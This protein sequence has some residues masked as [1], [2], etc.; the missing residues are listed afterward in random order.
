M[1]EPPKRLAGL[2]IQDADGVEAVMAANPRSTRPNPSA[3]SDALDIESRPAQRMRPKLDRVSDLKSSAASAAPTGTRLAAR[4]VAQQ[5]RE[6]SGD[7]SSSIPRRRTRPQRTTLAG[8]CQFEETLRPAAAGM[9]CPPPS[10]PR[11]IAQ[12]QHS[13]RTKSPPITQ[14]DERQLH[15][16]ELAAGGQVSTHCH[17]RVTTGVEDD[18]VAKTTRAAAQMGVPDASPSLA[19]RMGIAQRP[20]DH[21]DTRLEPAAPIATYRSIV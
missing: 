4:A 6:P 19:E 12:Q 8:V 21:C 7:R 11:W 1:T 20:A 2:R 14:P 15:L 16:L 3:M 18:G 9:I 17:G 5:A 10:P 13:I